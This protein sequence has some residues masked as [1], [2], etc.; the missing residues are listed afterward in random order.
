[1]NSKE[2]QLLIETKGDRFCVMNQRCGDHVLI[3]NNANR[4]VSEGVFCGMQ[5][6][7]SL[8][9]F[10]VSKTTPSVSFLRLCFQDWEFSRVG[11]VTNI[12]EIRFVDPV[13]PGQISSEALASKV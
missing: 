12:C 9:V 2:R 6:D 8:L 7:G 3:F 4:S 11:Y 13:H 1:M 10:Q 5:I